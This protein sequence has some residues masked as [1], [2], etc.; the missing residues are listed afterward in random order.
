V[1]RPEKRSHPSGRKSK[2][3]GRN[4]ASDGLG[5]SD[6]V[7][8]LGTTIP[9]LVMV[10]ADVTGFAA[11]TSGTWAVVALLPIFC[12]LPLL[13]RPVR[14]RVLALV[15]EIRGDQTNSTAASTRPDSEPGQP[16]AGR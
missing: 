15:K 11:G 2:Q 10:A 14:D 3:A 13:M 12:S 7:A 6:M 4:L 9:P 1:T 5:V 8:V 16:G